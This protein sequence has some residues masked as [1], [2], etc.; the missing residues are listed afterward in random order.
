MVKSFGG[1]N[2]VL[3]MCKGLELLSFLQ[4]CVYFAGYGKM[5]EYEHIFTDFLLDLARSK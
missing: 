3:D 1:S 5:P 2:I 4:T